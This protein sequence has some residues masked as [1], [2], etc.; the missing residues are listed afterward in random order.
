MLKTDCR[1]RS[2]LAAIIVSALLPD[3]F[4]TSPVNAQSAT[5]PPTSEP[6]VALAQDAQ[7]KQ[8]INESVLETG[9]MVFPKVT[10]PSNVGA[11]LSSAAAQAQ[12]CCTPGETRTVNVSS[13]DLWTSE[14]TRGT[15]FNP[16]GGPQEIVYSP[17]LSCWVIS[18]Y[19]RV[20]TSA[21]PPYKAWDDAQPANF[22]YVASSEYE[23]VMNQLKNY[24][25]KLDIASKYKA[26]LNAKIEEIVKSYSKYA[27]SI[28]TSHGQVRH[29]AQVQGRGLFKG[30]S[31]YQGHV[32]STEICCPPEVRDAAQLQATLTTW[33]DQ[34]ASKLPKGIPDWRNAP[35]SNQIQRAP[36]TLQVKPKVVPVEP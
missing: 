36:Q 10:P 23:S 11:K 25:L 9:G 14:N 35:K 21:N 3:G 22:A 19:S 32:R 16:A 29:Y 26:D 31:W 34:T 30:R 28:S 13:I 15:V 24:V 4:A 33:V 17:P 5:T 12:Y 7:A 1:L 6:H 27:S 20:V 2:L 18:T 8:V